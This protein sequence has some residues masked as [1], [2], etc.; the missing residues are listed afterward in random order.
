MRQ[1]LPPVLPAFLPRRRVPAAAATN[2]LQPL[3]HIDQPVA[4]APR[5]PSAAGT[6]WPFS[7]SHA[8][9]RP[10]SAT[11]SMNPPG[12]NSREMWTSEA[13]A[14]LTTLF[15]ASLKA[16]K[17][18]CRISADSAHAGTFNGTSRRQRIRRRAQELLREAPEI[19]HQAVQ[20]IV[21]GIDRPNDF[22]HRPR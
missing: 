8:N 11:T 7:G 12:F 9:P 1:P 17:T 2:F 14:C 22:I 20:R 16:R 3:L 21:F 19:R 13:A 10:L 5:D 4:G 15:K 18:L 6:V